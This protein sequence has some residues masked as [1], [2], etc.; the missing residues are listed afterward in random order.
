VTFES[1]AISTTNYYLRYSQY[2]TMPKEQIRKRGR[3]KPKV[4]DEYDTRKP[5]EVPAPATEQAPTPTE[6]QPAQA[7]PS[8]LHPDRLALLASGGRRPPPPHFEKREGEQGGEGGEGQREQ[9]QQPWGRQFGLVEEFPFGELDPD[10]KGFVKAAEDQ[11]KMWEGGPSD[12][13]GETR[14]G[15]C[16]TFYQ[17]WRLS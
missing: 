13:A 14:Q 9:Q 8:G 10:K 17:R 16:G 12:S 5:E 2:I 6:E 15:Q 3:R 7:G 1:F 11:I 4:E